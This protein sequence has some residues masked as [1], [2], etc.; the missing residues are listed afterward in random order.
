MSNTTDFLAADIG[1]SGGRVLL[2]R[3]DG[4]RIALSE[5]HRFAN[6]PVSI[7]STLH[8]D[9]LQLWQG[10]ITGMRRY[11][12][13]YH[14]TP[15]GIGVDTW[16]VDFGLL[17]RA[18]RLLANP[19]C[20]RDA[21]TNGMVDAATAQVPRSRIFEQ[22]GIQFMQINSL[23]QLYSMA[24]NHDPLLEAAETLLLMPDLLHYW[25]TGRA[26]VE[27]TNASTTQM[28]NCHTRGWAI[29]L[30]DELA[31]PHHF[32]PDIIA[33]ASVIGMLR[34]DVL[35]QA[36]MHG[37]VPVIASGTHDTANAVAAIPGLDQHS[38]YISSGTWSL[39][40][41]EMPH[42]VVG[43]HALALN[44]TNE[45]GIAG[46]IRLLKNVMGLWLLQESRR[47]W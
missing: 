32:L 17:D 30:L 18:G 10:V 1:A 20:Y 21:R 31:I 39:L 2:G 42:P 47:Q 43:E 41:V 35:E 5:L 25:M 11:A 3:F 24:R 27:Y 8:W 38:A 15:A 23:Y 22:T 26:A 40:G 16:G 6:E 44:V 45:G 37:R 4:R 33:P 36:G 13:E 34:A 46:T 28:L 29:D 14:T 19:I 12:G 9:V 7:H